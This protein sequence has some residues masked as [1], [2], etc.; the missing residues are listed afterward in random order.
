MCFPAYHVPD[1]SLPRRAHKR[2]YVWDLGK[3]ALFA[4]LQPMMRK[5]TTKYRVHRAASREEPGGERKAGRAGT[6][7]KGNVDDQ[8]AIGRAAV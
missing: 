1:T 8:S 4:T 6:G 5:Q 3:G 7:V 2:I